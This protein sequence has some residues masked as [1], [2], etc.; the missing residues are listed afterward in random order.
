[1]AKRIDLLTVPATYVDDVFIARKDEMVI[2]GDHPNT[3]GMPLVDLG[4]DVRKIAPDFNPRHPRQNTY[5]P[6]V[7][8]MS[9]RD[10]SVYLKHGWTDMQSQFNLRDLY[11][12]TQE[13]S[14]EREILE[15]RVN[16][17]GAIM[18][19]TAT[20]EDG[21]NYI[22]AEMRSKNVQVPGKVMPAPAGGWEGL[23]TEKPVLP[24]KSEPVW[25]DVYSNKVSIDTMGD[26]IQI[27]AY[28]ETGMLRGDYSKPKLTGIGRDLWMAFNPTL[29]YMTESNLT[30]E[31][32]KERARTAP[33]AAEHELTFGIIADEE[34]VSKFL[35]EER[36][37]RN[38]T[39]PDV[40]FKGQNIG[41][42]DAAMLAW[43]WNTFGITWSSE[44]VK[45]ME[46]KRDLHVRRTRSYPRDEVLDV[47]EVA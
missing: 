7:I 46:S 24:G 16:P 36:D 9:T 8:D 12:K 44:T 13:G 38:K 45:A 5:V 32:L 22:L 23:L 27:E 42:G 14:K 1:M 30:F 19:T 28:E 34:G 35:L 29:F 20:S 26:A 2:L 25:R 31:Q 37:E 10:G 47:S 33:E 21:Q 40:D 18:V 15:T 11:Q 41:T 3:S 17:V 4:I 6:N 43:G 39:L